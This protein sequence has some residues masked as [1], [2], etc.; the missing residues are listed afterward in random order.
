MKG[1]VWLILLG[2]I[3]LAA[4]YLLLQ[5]LFWLVLILLG[6]YLAYRLYARFTVPAGHHIN[7]GLLKGYLNERYGE[8]EGTKLYHRLVK[9]LQRKGYR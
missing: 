7:H 9:E 5:P 6:C 3:G 4:L 2:C 1:M 8:G